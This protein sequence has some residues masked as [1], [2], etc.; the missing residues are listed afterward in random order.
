MLKKNNNNISIKKP[1]AILF[2][3][4]NTLYEYE[5]ANKEA[6]EACYL[7]AKNLL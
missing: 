4:D 1:R 6:I 3:T 2:D 7:K 5:P